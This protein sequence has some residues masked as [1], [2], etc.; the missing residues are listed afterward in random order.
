METRNTRQTRPRTPGPRDFLDLLRAIAVSA[1]EA[2][3]IED[4]M[5]TCL[6]RVCALTGWPVGHLYLSARD[7]PSRL[8]P[9]SV[10]HLDDPNHF[11]EFRLITEGMS[12]ASGAGL[13]G[14]VLSS[15]EPL[16]IT[17]IPQDPS[18]P[19]AALAGRLGIQTGFAFPVVVGTDVVGVLE[20][21][22]PEVVEPDKQLLQVMTDIGTVLGR[23]VERKR[24]EEALRQSEE[25]FRSVAHSVIDAIV[26]ADSTG[27]IC[28][29]NRGAQLIFGYSEKEALGQPLSILMP[30]RYREDHRLG[31]ERV[32]TT[33]ETHV[34]GQVVEMHGLRRDGS[35]FPLELSLG[36]WNTDEGTFYSGI[37]RDIT[38]RKLVEQK[39]VESESRYRRLIEQASDGIAIYDQHGQ[40]IEVNSCASDML[41]YE[42]QELLKL[43]VTDVID[44][45]D[46]ARTP[47]RIAELKS[48]KTTLGERV[49][50]RKDGTRMPVELSARMLDNGQVQTI[51]RDVTE[52]K[53]IEDEIKRLNEDLERRVTARTA[54]LHAANEEL[55][56]EVAERK[57]LESQKDEFIAVASHELKTPIATIKGY[58]QLALRAVERSGDE[59]L[60]R[61]L[62]IV[63][64]KADQLA[65]LIAA[66]LDISRLENGNL[67]LEPQP[68]EL[69]AL[70][71][72]VIGNLQLTAPEFIFSLDLP[73]MPIIVDADPGRIEQVLTN[74]VENAVK[75]TGKHS[76]GQRKVEI[77]VTRADSE[78]IT[79]VRDYGVGIPANQ[80]GRVFD[81]FFRASNVASA[82]YP[83]PGM[84][85]GLFISHSLVSRHGGRMWVES[86][87]GAGSTFYFA[88]PLPGAL[89]PD[90]IL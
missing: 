65:K 66:M 60:A 18:F 70:V 63:N 30:E 29:W 24:A 81:R 52:R 40:I 69:S 87:E 33:G 14:R 82:R 35:E 8:D 53:R 9:A 44:P 77:S 43:S 55:K 15:G 34:I 50:V 3:T 86:V 51:I 4:A 12:F 57:R 71:S 54:R 76:E 36:T 47:L 68:F 19:R 49:L 21:F 90:Q 22:S 20:F 17:G 62:E 39:L 7:A 26:S 25:R 59:R 13:P 73:N 75:Y 72:K 48:G 1:N 28:S 11:E 2:A 56:R 27:N 23:V 89:E 32:N 67:P 61:N 58:T 46:L 6:D 79:A 74:L 10:W 45:E 80:Q 83:Y 41:G 37:I 31:M 38:A 16:W 84:G 42:P 85:L 5:Q 88:L 78:V 64:E